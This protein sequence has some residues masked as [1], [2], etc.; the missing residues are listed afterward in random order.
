[1]PFFFPDA[2]VSPL[3]RGCFTFLL[4][5]AYSFL[6][7]C[8]EMVYCSIGQRKL[9]EKRGFLN[10]LLCPIYGHGALVVL[11]ALDGGCENPLLTFLL[12]AVLTSAVE[13]ITSYGMEKLFHMRWWD[14]SHYRFHLRGRVCLLNSTLF[15]LA[16]V[17][18]CH[19]ANPPIARRLGALFAAGLGVP[20]ALVLGVLYLADIAVSVRSAL[21]VGSHLAKLHAVH[22]ELAQRLEQLRAGQRQFTEAQRQRL[23]EV[24]AEAQRKLHALYERQDFFDRRLLQSFPTLKSARHSEALSKL[25]EYLENRKQ[26]IKENKEM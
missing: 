23:E 22:D 9:C 16:S 6:G 4:L 17:F 26:F 1:M 7:W 19:F 3:Q 15:G 8:G 18:L 14:Y 2:C 11:L 12:G 5:L 25:R 13:Y 24:R 21:R 20:L 10:G